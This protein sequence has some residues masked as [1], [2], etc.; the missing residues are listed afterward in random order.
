M[1]TRISRLNEEEEQRYLARDSEL[2]VFP[3]PL[4]MRLIVTGIHIYT[5][6]RITFALIRS[7]INTLC[8]SPVT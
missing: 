7:L 4:G 1:P 3:V 8:G 2:F 6:S 5:R